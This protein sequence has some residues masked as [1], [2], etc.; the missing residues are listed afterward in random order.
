MLV[1][2]DLDCDVARAIDQLGA[3]RPAKPVAREPVAAPYH[4][5][6]D[7]GLARELEHRANR[8]AR[9][10]RRRGAAKEDR[11]A[12]FLPRSEHVYTAI[13]GAL[14]LLSG[15]LNAR[16][17]AY[18]SGHSLDLELIQKIGGEK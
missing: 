8:L 18:R 10:L 7:A 3:A 4:D 1:T 6:A 9:C 5:A 11:V 17:T 14:A 15:R 12:V 2:H 16:I 13:L